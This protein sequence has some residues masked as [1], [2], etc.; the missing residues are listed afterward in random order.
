MAV[1][2]LY[3]HETTTYE[4]LGWK[5]SDA[6]LSGIERLNAYLGKEVVQVGRHALR[7]H[8]LVGIVRV[9]QTTIQILPKIDRERGS[10]DSQRPGAETDAQSASQNLLHMLSETRRLNPLALSGMSLQSRPSD[11]FELL[12]RLFAVELYSQVQRGAEHAY[13]SVEDTLPVLR[14]R[15]RLA[16]Q[17]ARA[18]HERHRFDV[19]YDE[20]NTDTPL[21]R[22]FRFVISK[23]LLVAVD[24]LNRSLLV[25]LD[26][27]LSGA[28]KL[29]RVTGDE[30][31]R[32]LW[33]R[34]NERFRG[35]FQLAKLFLTNSTPQLQVGNLPLFAFLIDM[36]ELFEEFV[37][38]FITRHGATLW[39]SRVTPIAVHIQSRGK[40][41]FL[42]ERLPEQLP[43]F[44][45]L[46]DLLLS[47]PLGPP[48]LVIDTKYKMVD[49]RAA[50]LGVAEADF[51]QMLAYS[52]RLRASRVLLLYPQAAGQGSMFHEF[53]IPDHATQFFVA[54]L[55]LRRPIN[56]IDELMPDFRTL[57]D[58][59]LLEAR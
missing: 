55:D 28:R 11:W 51:Y 47:P 21:N 8:Q 5:S 39:P 17:L 36:N 42:A 48:D 20:F 7:T 15:W 54:T 6:V 56:R 57:L 24:S 19:V 38:S 49:E 27:L 1:I 44:K 40:Q 18:P 52:T 23:L 12:T 14:G 43:A 9:G 3:E 16:H 41:T 10:D 37:A 33:T 30:L 4:D 25:N 58:P 59:L 26:E 2:P 50:K 13:I 46:P 53:R 35:A 32:L 22:I 45:L 29:S 34:L 31:D